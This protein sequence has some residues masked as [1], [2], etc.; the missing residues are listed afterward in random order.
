MRRPYSAT[1]WSIVMPRVSSTSSSSAW[2]TTAVSEPSSPS[3]FCANLMTSASWSVPAKTMITL[4]MTACAAAAS[5]SSITPSPFVSSTGPARLRARVAHVEDA[6]VLQDRLDRPLVLE[7]GD[8]LEARRRILVGVGGRVGRLLEDADLLRE[9]DVDRVA[10]G[11]EE[12]E[13]GDAVDLEGDRLLAWVEQGG[14]V[15]AALVAEADHLGAHL[16]ARRGWR[17]AP[18]GP[19]LR[20]RSRDA[21]PMT[22]SGWTSCGST[23]S[24]VTVSR[25]VDVLGR[26]EDGDRGRLLRRR[27][28]PSAAG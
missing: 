12:V 25:D 4:S 13:A 22:A 23:L 20:W 19:E 11:D 24:G 1:S 15:D 14:D 21:V 27:S 3:A 10:G 2:R 16:R 18:A 17:R 5:F 7:A 8:G 6:L 9:D 28:L 26:D